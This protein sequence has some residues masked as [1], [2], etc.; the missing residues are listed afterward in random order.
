[1]PWAPTCFGYTPAG[2]LQSENGPWA[3]DTVT[4]TYVQGLRTAL[5]LSQP[6]T[7]WSQ[8][9]GFD[10]MLAH[11]ERDF[12]GRHVRLYFRRGEPASR[13]DQANFAAKRREHHKQF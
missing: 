10:S 8:S 11:D 9:Y 7:N 13:P 12:S 2:Q 4:Y 5:T 1:M 6:T 3:N